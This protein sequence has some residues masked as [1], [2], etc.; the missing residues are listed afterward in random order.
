[1]LPA[2]FQERIVIG[3]CKIL[4]VV[5]LLGAW[6]TI[7]KLHLVNCSPAGL[8]KACTTCN[9]CR[10]SSQLEG[11]IGGAPWRRPNSLPSVLWSGPA[12]RSTCS[13]RLIWLCRDRG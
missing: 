2:N 5:I 11:R 6:L 4:F 1:M 10:N 3:S 7:P 9:Y 13:Y 12:K 8:C